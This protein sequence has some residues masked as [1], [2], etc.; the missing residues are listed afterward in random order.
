[1]HSCFQPSFCSIFLDMAHYVC[2]KSNE[3]ALNIKQK[4]RLNSNDLFCIK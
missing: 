2:K 3:N 4:Y 1:M